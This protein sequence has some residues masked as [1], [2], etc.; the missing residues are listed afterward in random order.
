MHVS[1]QTAV[2]GWSMIMGDT[3]ALRWSHE[4]CSTRAHSFDASASNH[5]QSDQIGLHC[6]TPHLLLNHDQ[7]G[8]V[9]WQSMAMCPTCC[10]EWKHE[11]SNDL[12]IDTSF[13]CCVKQKLQSSLQQCTF[14]TDERWLTSSTLQCQMGSETEAAEA[15]QW[16]GAC[17]CILQQ[18]LQLQQPWWAKAV[19]VWHGFTC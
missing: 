17:H 1:S 5:T 3:T 2:Y 7:P 6:I 11:S 10:S 16:E 8:F 18:C 15:N 12:P 13:E 19:G 9:V 14:L 4:D